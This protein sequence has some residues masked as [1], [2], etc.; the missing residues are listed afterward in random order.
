MEETK[1]SGMSKDQFWNLIEK[2]KEVCGTVKQQ[3]ERQ[4]ESKQP[5]AAA[6]CHNHQ[7]SGNAHMRTGKSRRRTLAD[8]LGTLYQII[9]ESVIVSRSGRWIAWPICSQCTR[10]RLWKI[11]SPG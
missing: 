8:L 10:S 7:Y 2:A 9:E 5:T 6:P 3:I 4:Q 1:R 11:G